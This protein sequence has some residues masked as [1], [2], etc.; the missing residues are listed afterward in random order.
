MSIF[1][2]LPNDLI[3]KIIRESDGGINTHKMKM[4]PL[5][6]HINQVRVEWARAQGAWND[7]SFWGDAG[8]PSWEAVYHPLMMDRVTL[9]HAMMRQ[10]E[11]YDDP[12]KAYAGPGGLYPRPAKQ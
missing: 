11:F 5:I 10:E 1:K 12:K 6:D 2:N 9:I 8:Q 3:M 7:D 4:K